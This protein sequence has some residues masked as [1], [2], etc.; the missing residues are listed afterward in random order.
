MFALRESGELAGITPEK[1]Q[2]H[3]YIWHLAEKR[4]LS[5][6]AVQIFR[7]DDAKDLVQ[8]HSEPK[9]PI[10]DVMS[11]APAITPREQRLVQAFVCC[12]L[13]R[14]YFAHHHYLDQELLRSKESAF[15]LGGIVLTVLFLL[16]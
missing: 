4:R 11:W 14:N 7:S 3:R 16:G 2:L 12:L 8:L 6:R 13:A 10:H 5:A 15:M 1:R 9:T